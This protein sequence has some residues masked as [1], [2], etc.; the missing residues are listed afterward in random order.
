MCLTFALALKKVFY[1]FTFP[2]DIPPCDQATSATGRRGCRAG[3]SLGPGPGEMRP[4]GGQE[5]YIVMLTIIHLRLSGDTMGDHLILGA[6]LTREGGGL[7][8][9]VGSERWQDDPIRTLYVFQPWGINLVHCCVMTQRS[10]CF[11]LPG[12]PAQHCAADIIHLN[13]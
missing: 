11:S 13:V 5:D 3:E 2:P 6:T 12:R 7:M 8:G 10:V 1:L 9:R 4:S